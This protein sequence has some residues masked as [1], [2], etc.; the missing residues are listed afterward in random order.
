M[1]VPLILPTGSKRGDVSGPLSFEGTPG[2]KR[3]KY[4]RIDTAYTEIHVPQGTNILPP[5]MMAQLPQTV[6]QDMLSMAVAKWLSRRHEKRRAGSGQAPPQISGPLSALWKVPKVMA[7]FHHIQPPITSLGDWIAANMEGDVDLV[8]K[9]S[10][11]MLVRRSPSLRDDDEQG[12]RAEQRAEEQRQFFDTLPEDYLTEEELNL[13]DGLLSYL[14]ARDTDEPTSLSVA[15][16]PGGT[17]R[18]AIAF[19]KMV[20]LPRQVPIQDWI[21]NRIGQ[22]IELCDSQQGILFQLAGAATASGF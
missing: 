14:N 5:E 2:S 11:T 12:Q 18:N 9:G 15:C 21:S 4:E 16:Q 20:L 3:A 8:P 22:D 17:V 13:R 10:E 6:L 19:A 7:V 1:T